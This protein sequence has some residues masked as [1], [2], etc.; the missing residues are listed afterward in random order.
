L[1][2]T[3]AIPAISQQPADIQEEQAALQQAA[4]QS[5][6]RV[7]SLDD[8][9]MSMVSAYN[10]ELSRAE[11]LQ[12][13]NDNMRQLLASQAAERER[14][15]VELREVEQVRQAIVP[16]M[17]EMVEVLDNFISLDQPMLVEERQ[18]RINQLQSIVTRADVEIAEKYRRIME[19]Y[20]IEAE[21][22]QSLEAYEAQIPIG[23]VERTVDILRV[24]RVA[25]YYLSLNREEAGIWNPETGRW[26][27]LSDDYL[28]SL[29]YALRM[30][31]EQAPPNLVNLPLWTR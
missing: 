13:Y 1:L 30:A 27:T 17:V 24:G 7:E 2:L 23:G 8:E 22:G 3:L 12:T 10:R 20:L 9:T 11:E 25:L 26:S 28:G 16:L 4:G 5:Q 31:R 15:N 21:Y 29:D 14:F 6:D 19:S 18:A